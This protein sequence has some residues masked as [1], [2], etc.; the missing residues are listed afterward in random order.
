MLQKWRGQ[1]G[2]ARQLAVLAQWGSGL[3]PQA[4]SQ[5]RHCPALRRRGTRS[6]LRSRRPWG[7][8]LWAAG[9]WARQA[10]E[11]GQ[12]RVGAA[13]AR[14]SPGARAAT[15]C[16]ICSVHAAQL[17]NSLGLATSRTTRSLSQHSCGAT[18][19]GGRR[20][21]GAEVVAP[22]VGRAAG[23]PSPARGRAC[24]PPHLCAG[25]PS[26]GTARLQVVAQQ[27]AVV[28]AAHVLQE[29]GRGERGESGRLKVC[30][31]ADGGGP[32]CCVCPSCPA[33]K[34]H[35][36]PSAPL[37][38]PTNRPTHLHGPWDAPPA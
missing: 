2:R 13:Q 10:Q 1:Q 19:T 32:H 22:L 33:H 30:G 17:I 24:Q 15:P 12:Q 28:H 34:P 31:V 20:S 14:A 38:P 6:K 5:A 26:E 27:A 25:V 35:S 29:R 3:R 18:D 8:S 7:R 23:P 36:T 37:A 21:R 9:L 16:C 11:E 4:A